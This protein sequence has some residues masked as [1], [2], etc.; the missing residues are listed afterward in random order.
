MPVMNGWQASIILTEKQQSGELYNK[1][2]IIAHTAY[3][4]PRDI[5]KCYECGMAGVLPKP[6]TV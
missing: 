3:S 5:S 2:K 4:S 6:A 1:M